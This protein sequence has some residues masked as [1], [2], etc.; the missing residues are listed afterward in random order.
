MPAPELKLNIGE[1][2]E[3]ARESA[4]YGLRLAAE[5]LKS[6]SQKQVPHEVGDLERSA[7]ASVDEGALEA[8]VSYDTP[9]AV[10]QHEDLTMRHDE[11]RKAK[12]LEDPMNA[13]VDTMRDL[14]AQQMQ[15]ELS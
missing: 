6:E 15:Q 3:G 14:I 8:T 4:A 7:V 1:V 5:H 13:E 11:G 2:K 9:Y 12:Y 10:P